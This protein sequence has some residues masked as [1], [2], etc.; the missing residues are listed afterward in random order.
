[1]VTPVK[2]PDRKRRSL[3]IFTFGFTTVMQTLKMILDQIKIIVLKL[4]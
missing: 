4:I 2:K 1:M 3:I